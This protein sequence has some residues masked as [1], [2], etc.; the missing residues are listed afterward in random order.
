[1]KSLEA[2][3]APDFCVRPSL[4]VRA[5]RLPEPPNT[6]NSSKKTNA[7]SALRRLRP[8]SHPVVPLEV[9][10]EIQENLM[11][12]SNILKELKQTSLFDLYRLSVAINQ[13]LED[14]R[15]L[16]V[17]KRCLRP[18]QN[19]I[20]FDDTENRL[21]K[22][23][24]IKLMRTR[25][26][27]ENI[28]DQHRWEIPLYC[29]NLDEVN[30]DIIGSSKMGLDKSQLKVGDL[31]G[32]QDKQNNDVHGKIIRLNQKTATIKTNINTE[33][34]VGYEWLYLV[35]NVEQEITHLIEDRIVDEKKIIR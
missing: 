9:L 17:I 10:L 14:P 16:S 19:I 32:F 23:K 20:Y 12:Y 31:V 1:M 11:D 6:V 33:W 34:R 24:V 15:R 18:G 27:V 35:I 26:L 13:L 7:V 4:A 21:I 29:V 22:A 3:A 2:L 8:I 28:D 5:T 25:L 30:T